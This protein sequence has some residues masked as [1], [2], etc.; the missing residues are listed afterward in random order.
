MFK[1]VWIIAY[2]LGWLICIGG[3]AEMVSDH[4]F[5]FDVLSAFT[6]FWLIIH[7]LVI[8]GMSLC[9]FLIG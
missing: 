9:K 7:I 5:D 1:Y 3:I 8:I 4:I 6:Q 2:I